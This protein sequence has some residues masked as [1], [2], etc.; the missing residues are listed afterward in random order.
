MLA[1]GLFAMQFSSH[2]YHTI[3]GASVHDHIAALAQ[4]LQVRYGTILPSSGQYAQPGIQQ[5]QALS[6]ANHAQFGSPTDYLGPPSRLH[7]LVELIQGQTLHCSSLSK[8]ASGQIEA[9]EMHRSK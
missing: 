2:P 3:H 1:G 8:N 5:G 6:I 9:G 7:L 4:M